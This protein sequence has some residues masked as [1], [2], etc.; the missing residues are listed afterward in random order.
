MPPESGTRPIPTKPGTKL[1]ASEAIRT[2]Q[3][4][5]SE[6]PAPAAGPFTAASTGFS[7]ARIARM[8]GW[9]VSSQPVADV[10]RRLLELAQVLAGAEA[11]PCAGDHDSAH[12]VRGRGGQPLAQA[13]RA[14]RELNA[15]KTSGRL[16]VSVSTAPSRLVSTSSATVGAYFR[17]RKR[18]TASCVS[19]LS[20]ESA[21]QSRAW[22][23]VSCHE[24]SRHQFSCCFA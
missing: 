24:T 16:S 4:A 23:T 15:L 11:A 1:A 8:F 17:S 6:R 22:P 5:A 21:S 3:A 7:R 13:P 19:G 20:I 18:L 12:V 10:A 9:Y 2:S 14:G